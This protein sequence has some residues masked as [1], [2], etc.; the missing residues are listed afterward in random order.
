MQDGPDDYDRVVRE[1][2]FEKRSQPLDRIPTEEELLAEENKRLQQ[3][4]VN[5]V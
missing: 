2:I 5:I 4:E 1:L 3:L